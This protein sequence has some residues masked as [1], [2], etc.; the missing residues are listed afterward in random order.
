MLVYH[1]EGVA[2]VKQ[3]CQEIEMEWS[4]MEMVWNF[5]GFLART[6]GD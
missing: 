4:G 3:R 1:L 6:V 5:V 2:R